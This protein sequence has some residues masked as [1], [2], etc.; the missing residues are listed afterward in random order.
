VNRLTVIFVCLMLCLAGATVPTDAKVS[1]ADTVANRVI[2][3]TI[4][5][6]I[7]K[8]DDVDSE[9]D[10]GPQ[11]KWGR[12]FSPI[13]AIINA[14]GCTIEWDV[15]TRKVSIVLGTKTIILTIGNRYAV[16]NGESVS[17]DSN[18]DLVP[19]VQAPGR[20]MLPVRFI[21]EQLGAL[22]TW[23][24]TLQRVTLTLKVTSPP[25]PLTQRVVSFTPSQT[26]GAFLAL[27]GNE[28]IDVIELNGTYYLP[29]I[30]INIDRTRPVVVRP[31]AGATVVM[32]GADDVMGNPQ[33]MFG[34]DAPAGNI[35]MQGLIFD[36]FILRKQGIVQGFDCHDI[37]L[38]D[39][40]VRNSRADGT[41]ARPYQAWAIYLSATPSEFPTNFTA[42]RWTVVASARGMNGLKVQGGSHITVSG[43][44]VSHAYFAAYGGGSEATLTDFILDDWA[45]TDTGGADWGSP[46]MSVGIADASGRFSNMHGMNSGILL[47]MGKPQ[48]TDGGGNSL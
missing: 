16:V 5:S 38:N 31:A 27:L 21:A 17:I 48:L 25:L 45:I 24:S 35:T 29:E 36:G 22:V 37:T 10:A 23:N 44:S 47:N 39:M 18:P 6:K 26:S 43:W 46:N 11:I 42:N 7:L 13:A 19:Y 34:Y 32:S 28:S 30:D 3:T 9:I 41:Y 20:T 40:V 12:T 1:A 2:V 4:G 8:V 14:L 33:F 15:A